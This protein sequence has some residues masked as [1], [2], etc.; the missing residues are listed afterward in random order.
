MI[1]Y[2]TE[3]FIIHKGH[4][5]IQIFLKEKGVLTLDSDDNTEK[6]VEESKGQEGQERIMISDTDTIIDPRAMMIESLNANIANGTMTRSRGSNDFA[7]RAEISW[8]KPLHKIQKVDAV[9]ISQFTWV[10][11]CG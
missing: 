10:S 4:H 11:C 7:I 8:G 3:I 2:V 5:E 6:D 9:F 1:F